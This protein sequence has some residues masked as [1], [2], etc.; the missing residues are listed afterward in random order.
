MSGCWVLC[1]PAAG[2]ASGG[3][4][5]RVSVT[6]RAASAPGRLAGR[7]PSPQDV[8]THPRARLTSGPPTLKM[9]NGS[10]VKVLP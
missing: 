9:Q 4:V 2:L 10:T 1:R 6:Q 5:C 7:G 8:K 3:L